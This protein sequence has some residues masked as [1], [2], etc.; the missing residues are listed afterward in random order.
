MLCSVSSNAQLIM[1]IAKHT[2]SQPVSIMNR[3]SIMN[4]VSYL[5][6]CHE[7]GG[8]G[9]LNYKVESMPKLNTTIIW[10]L[11]LSGMWL[12][13][14]FIHETESPRP[15]HFK[16]SLWWKRRS[17]SKFASHYAWGTNKVC[18]CKVVVKSTWTPTWHQMDCVSWSL[19]LFSKTTSWR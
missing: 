7:Q 6:Q 8:A 5:M 15:L 16:H 9:E 10:H 18:E 19:G 3:I 1:R 11:S 4:W 13:A 12:M 17:R 14:L 2:G